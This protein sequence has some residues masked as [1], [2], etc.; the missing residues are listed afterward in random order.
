[1]ISHEAANEARLYYE[2]LFMIFPL[3][4]LSLNQLLTLLYRVHRTCTE[5]LMPELLEQCP[6]SR[7]SPCANAPRS[8][9]TGSSREWIFD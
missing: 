5:K 1:M 2:L 4:V 7:E 9:Q 6:F 3:V 8:T